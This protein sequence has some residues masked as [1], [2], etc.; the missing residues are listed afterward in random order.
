MPSRCPSCGASSWQNTAAGQGYHTGQGASYAN[1]NTNPYPYSTTQ[2]QQSLIRCSFCSYTPTTHSQ[3]L[4]MPVGPSPS[5]KR[6]GPGPYNDS[7][8]GSYPD[9]DGRDHQQYP[10]HQRQ[11]SMAF[12]P[13]SSYPGTDPYDRRHQTNFVSGHTYGGQNMGVSHVNRVTPGTGAYSCQ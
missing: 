4:P 5:H 7:F 13:T 3:P 8:T 11:S 10:Q 6:Y 1:M 9:R 12:N 2:T